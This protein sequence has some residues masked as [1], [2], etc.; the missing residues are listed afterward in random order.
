ME[1]SYF[2]DRNGSASDILSPTT[3]VSSPIITT[4]GRSNAL[5]SRITSVLST[6][7]ADLDLRDALETLD[8]RDFT[9]TPDSR[10]NLRLDL[11]QEVIRCNGEI[12][13]DFGQVAEV[14][15]FPDMLHCFL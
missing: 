10:R 5:S 4:A 11:Q 1:T 12:I 13:K 2:Q 6:S 7:Y 14:C 8:S 3:G 15:K 9:N